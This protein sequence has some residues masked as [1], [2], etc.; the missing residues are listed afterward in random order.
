VV[1]KILI[2]WAWNMSGSSTVSI[3]APV[4]ALATGSRPAASLFA[5]E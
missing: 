3:G 5:L 4:A 1:V 2:D